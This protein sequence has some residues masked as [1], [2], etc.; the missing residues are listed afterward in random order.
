MQDGDIVLFR[1]N[2]WC[3]GDVSFCNICPFC[4]ILKI[5]GWKLFFQLPTSN[6]RKI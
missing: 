5:R 3:I 6:F 1:F 2:V 4:N